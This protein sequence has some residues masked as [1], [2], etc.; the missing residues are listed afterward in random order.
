MNVNT[1]KSTYS[2]MHISMIS[3]QTTQQQHKVSMSDTQD[4]QTDRETREHTVTKENKTKQPK[5]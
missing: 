3:A 4:R 5:Q 1:T 2:R